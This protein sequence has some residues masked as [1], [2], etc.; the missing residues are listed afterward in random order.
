MSRPLSRVGGTSALTVNSASEHSHVHG[1]DRVVFDPV[2]EHRSTCCTIGV[3]SSFVVVVWRNEMQLRDAHQQNAVIERY[4]RKR[5]V[6]GILPFIDAS[7]P[8]PSTE[9]RAV[10]NEAVVRFAPPVVGVGVAMVGDG[11]RS[12]MVRG[13][14][15]AIQLMS[16]A[17]VPSRV[18]ATEH[19]ASVW[20]RERM[21]VLAEGE[22]TPEQ[23]VNVVRRLRDG[24]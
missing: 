13:V 2:I 7:V 20:L 4:A 23:L 19:E 10:L 15:T 3:C 9:V 18:F 11:F 16:R 1:S 6:L 8:S 21:G 5:K 14:V 24:F 12:A 17:P 22:P